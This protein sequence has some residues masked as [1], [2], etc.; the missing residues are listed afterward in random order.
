MGLRE[1]APSDASS[2]ENEDV[3]ALLA[4]FENICNLEPMRPRSGAAPYIINI[5]GAFVM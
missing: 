1:S 2:L 5:N 4:L 3:R